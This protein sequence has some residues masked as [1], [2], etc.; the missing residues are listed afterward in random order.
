M[1]T[2]PTSGPPRCLDREPW[3]AVS[4]FHPSGRKLVTT[5]AKVLMTNDGLTEPFSD[6]RRYTSGCLEPATTGRTGARRQ[7]AEVIQQP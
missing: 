1:R 6:S 2:D 7:E 3:R 4:R 5:M